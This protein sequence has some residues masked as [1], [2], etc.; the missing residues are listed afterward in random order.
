[1]SLQAEL[2]QM[3]AA[4]LERLPEEARAIM[5]KATTDLTAS[6]IAEKAV[7][8]GGSLPDLTLPNALG[9]PVRLHDLLAGGPLIINFYRG[10]WCPYCNLELRAYQQALPEI[11]AAG[12]QLVAVSPELPDL[13]LSAQEKNELTFEV[14]SD[15][16][17]KLAEALGIVFELPAPLKAL[18]E[19][20]GNKLDEKNGEAGYR[21]P[22]PATYV[23]ARDGT[24]LKAHVDTDY[25]FRLDPSDAVAALKSDG[26]K[27]A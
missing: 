24:I 10:G 17:Q 16:Q 26:E 23:V 25:R 5:D 1:M 19:K 13:S 18:Y 27:A 11:N 14:L 21:L 7:K 3:R 6:G 20:F 22:I 4:A 8:E 12:G 9:E 15:T 2:E